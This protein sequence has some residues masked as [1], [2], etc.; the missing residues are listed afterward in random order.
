VS[1]TKPRV[2]PALALPA[3]SLATIVIVCAAS[4]LPSVASAV[5]I[6]KPPLASRTSASS[7]PSS[8]W[9]CAVATPERLSNTCPVQRE[10]GV[11]R[12]RSVAKHD[13][14]R[15]RIAR[16]REAREHRIA[17]LRA[18]L[19]A[20][21]V[22]EFVVDAAIDAAATGLLRRLCEAAEAARDAGQRRAGR[23]EGGR[24][25]ESWR[26]EPWPQPC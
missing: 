12:R 24:V 19:L 4:A 1:S 15:L 21:L 7:A 23:G 6:V 2:T 22:G 18:E 11:R 20:S 9:N 8:I 26:R 17:D 25:A 13:R 5:V 14:R 10:I 3:A 16:Q